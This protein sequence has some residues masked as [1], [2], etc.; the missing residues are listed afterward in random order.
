MVFLLRISVAEIRNYGVD[1]TL[2]KNGNSIVKIFITFEKLET[3][4]KILLPI[5]ISKFDFSTSGKDISCNLIQN[6]VSEIECKFNLSEEGKTIQLNFET[7]D[8]VSKLNKTFYFT[9]D[10]SVWDNINE[11]FIVVRLPEGFVLSEEGEIYPQDATITSDGRRIVIVWR[12]KDIL[13]TQPLK[14]QFAYEST[15]EEFVF[16]WRALLFISLLMVF[17]FIFIWKRMRKPEEL[18]LS[19]LDEYERKVMGIIK[20]AGEIKQKRIVQQTNLSKAKVSRVVKSLHERGLIEVRRIGRTNLIKLA[21][22]KF[23]IFGR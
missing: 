21:R 6:K 16:S 18:I 13:P 20:N 8:L 22:K 23:G 9:G 10:F 3:D 5:K 7:L 1:V 4:F 17:M 2:E 14:F 19:V 11:S 12:Y 15:L